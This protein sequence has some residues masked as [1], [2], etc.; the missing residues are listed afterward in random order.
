MTLM[1]Q[2]C[3][4]EGASMA[5]ETSSSTS[6]LSGGSRNEVTNR[7]IADP[8]IVIKVAN[9]MFEKMND[10]NG[11]I[12]LQS[13]DDDTDALRDCPTVPGSGAV[14]LEMSNSGSLIVPEEI[15]FL[16]SYGE[17]ST[18]PSSVITPKFSISAQSSCSLQQ[19]RKLAPYLQIH[20]D[21]LD[22]L[23]KKPFNKSEM[24]KLRRIY[25]SPIDCDNVDTTKNSC[26]G[27]TWNALST[28]ATQEEPPP[29]QPNSAIHGISGLNYGLEAT[30][31]ANSMP[32]TIYKKSKSQL[33]RKPSYRC[34]KDVTALTVDA[35]SHFEGPSRECQRTYW[36]HS[37]AEV[38]RGDGEILPSSKRARGNK[39][40]IDL[41]PR[42]KVA[43]II[44]C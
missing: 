12:L 32:S 10:P 40:R 1:W 5:E 21:P 34:L 28:A 27:K 14:I 33:Y 2:D 44:A 19:K 41:Y 35:S 37:F 31:R 42:I 6:S 16:R 29:F 43:C 3:Q 13:A 9:R 17:T 26:K 25:S 18:D 22:G 4:L 15:G 38:E 39:L 11:T 20:C 8:K 30:S 23:S 36:R 24:W 7:D